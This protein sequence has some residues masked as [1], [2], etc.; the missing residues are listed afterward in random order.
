[1]EAFGKFSKLLFERTKRYSATSF[2]D[3]Y[4]CNQKDRYGVIVYVEKERGSNLL[5]TKHL[6]FPT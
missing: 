1:M 5:I 4:T 3:Y 6:M 2:V